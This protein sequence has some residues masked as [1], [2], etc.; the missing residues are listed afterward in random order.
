M[1]ADTKMIALSQLTDEDVA[2]HIAVVVRG[3][4]VSAQKAGITPERAG[5]ACAAAFSRTPVSIVARAFML[6]KADQPDP[7]P[8]K[9]KTYP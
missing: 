9:R 7:Q 1:T 3:F 5:H 2:R 8:P 6:A 4:I